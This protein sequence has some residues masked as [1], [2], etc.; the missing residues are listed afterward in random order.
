MKK[1][2]IL[3]LPFLVSFSQLTAGTLASV[4]VTATNRNDPSSSCLLTS[5][6]API[7]CEISVGL[8]NVAHAD[9]NASASLGLLSLHTNAFA[10]LPGSADA[11]AMAQYDFNIYFPGAPSGTL[12]GNYFI[13]GSSMASF[14]GGNWE[15]DIG[16]G[17]SELHFLPPP[18]FPVLMQSVMIPFSYV[19]GQT[20]AIKGFISGGASGAGSDSEFTDVSLRLLG[21]VD[22]S[23]NAVPFAEVPEPMLS[24]GLVV[25]LA[26]LY[27]CTNVGG[28]GLTKWFRRV[29]V[30]PAP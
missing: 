3:F 6:G 4:R 5:A 27:M 13:S 30:H 18:N 28:P 19:A 24:Q 11:Q 29:R 25:F 21:F 16:Q 14:P 1:P 7:V 10:F 9:G 23:G 26:L 12:T 22:Q 20:L 17:Q 2:A 8:G 15:I